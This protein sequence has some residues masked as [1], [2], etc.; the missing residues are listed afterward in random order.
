MVP[1]QVRTN[2]V[3]S[4][5]ANEQKGEC[6]SL[7][8]DIFDGVRVFLV[9]GIAAGIVYAILATGLIVGFMVVEAIKGIFKQ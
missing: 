3:G 8:I 9:V 6:M 2:S 4:N 7:I 5:Q 1:A